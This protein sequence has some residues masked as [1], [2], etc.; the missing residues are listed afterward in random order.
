MVKLFPALYKIKMAN[1]KIESIEELKGLKEAKELKKI[2]V[3]GNPFV[4][5]DKDYA[6]TIFDMLNSLEVVDGKDKNEEEVESTIYDDE[7]EEFEDDGEDDEE[8]D[9][10]D[11]EE[12]FE[13]E[14]DNEDDD[15]EDEKPK[16]SKKH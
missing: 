9:E 2:E 13:E 11:D 12:E 14:E 7:G 5:K 3:K 4:E 10:E 8:F 15:D 1:N 6:K 16:K